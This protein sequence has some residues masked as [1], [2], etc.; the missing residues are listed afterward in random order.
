MSISR[1]AHRQRLRHLR[2]LGIDAQGRPRTLRDIDPRI[3]V[4]VQR[5]I[6][7]SDDAPRSLLIYN[8]D[9]TITKHAAE[10]SLPAE[11][12]EHLAKKLG[13]EW[14]RFYTYAIVD[15]NQDLHLQFGEL[16]PEQEW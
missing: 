15:E 2:K 6:E 1:S 10:A 11:V 16:A 14:L 4:K 5:S 7:A 8:Q 13:A 9:R 3:I 12:S